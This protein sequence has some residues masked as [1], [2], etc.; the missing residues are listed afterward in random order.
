[1]NIA[2]TPQYLDTLR[3]GRLSEGPS[4]EPE[5]I[6]RHAGVDLNSTVDEVPIFLES[7]PHGYLGRES[8]ELADL[9]KPV[10][11]LT[12]IVPRLLRP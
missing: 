2:W 9:P 1:V 5:V 7:E 10:M 6:G 11:S 3:G 4:G 12:M 8:D